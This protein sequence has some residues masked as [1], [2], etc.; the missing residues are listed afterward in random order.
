MSGIPYVL[1]ETIF[2]TPFSL[3]GEDNST[4]LLQDSIWFIISDVSEL[5]KKGTNTY[6][7]RTHS[8]DTEHKWANF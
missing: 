1:K 4:T 5:A 2:K 3:D 7:L 6:F 8:H